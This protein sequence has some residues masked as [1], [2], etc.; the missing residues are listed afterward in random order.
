MIEEDVAADKVAKVR[1]GQVMQHFESHIK[2]LHF[3]LN[4]V[5]SH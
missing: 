3:I 2:S 5:R 1:K 4:V